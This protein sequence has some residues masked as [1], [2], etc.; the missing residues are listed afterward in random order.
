MKKLI[1]DIDDEKHKKLKLYALQ[2][3]TSLKV[4]VNDLL[5]AFMKEKGV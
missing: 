5:D 2:Y 3:D 4:I 1:V